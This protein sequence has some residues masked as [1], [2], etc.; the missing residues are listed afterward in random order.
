M[1]FLDHLHKVCAR[2]GLN[3]EEARDAMESILNGSVST[4]QIAAF[5]AA[6]KVLGDGVDE[7]TGFAEAMRAHVTK[8]A[9]PPGESVLDTCGTGG[10]GLSTFNIS[11]AV[12]IVVAACGVKVAKHGNRAFSSHTGSADVLEML[13]VK[14]D[15]TPS[16]MSHCLAQAGIAFLYAPNVHPAMKHAAEARR[17][18]KMRTVFNLLGPL[19]NP[20]GAQHQLIGAPNFEAARIMA[21]ALAQL[22]TFK[23]IVVHGEDGLDEVTT[24]GRSMMYDIV[25]NSITRRAIKPDDFGVPMATMDELR[26]ETGEDSARTIRDIL[27]VVP[28]AKLDIVMVNAAVALYAAGVVPDFKAGVAKAFGVIASGAAKAKLEDLKRVS[29]AV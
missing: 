3:R 14:I 29:N 23:S 2:K 10:D 12:A 4:A 1:P 7:V 5:L 9:T 24:T 6:V 11:T 28:S 20:A 19:S 17:E 25:G 21:Q 18:L 15:L 16:Q 26:A 22:G 27:D 13:G 8:V